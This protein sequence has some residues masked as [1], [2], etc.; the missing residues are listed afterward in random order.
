MAPIKLFCFPYAGASA[1]TFTGLAHRLSGHFKVIAMALPGRGKRRTQQ[2][3]GERHLA[4]QAGTSAP[5][6]TRR[7]TGV[8]VPA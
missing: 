1:R 5:L 6:R 4:W 7:I 8:R 2:P 3:V